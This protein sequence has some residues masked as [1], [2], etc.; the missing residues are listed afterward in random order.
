MSV[1]R[2]PPLAFRLQSTAVLVD[3]TPLGVDGPIGL[4]PSVLGLCGLCYPEK[5]SPVELYRVLRIE[6]LLIF[7]S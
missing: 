7:T 4:A 6:I 3:A 1:L 5:T 2:P